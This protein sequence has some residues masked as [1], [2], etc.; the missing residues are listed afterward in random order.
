MK[1]HWGVQ[2]YPQVPGHEIVG[3][4]AAVGKNVTRFKIGDRAGVGC[5]VNSTL[6]DSELMQLENTEQYSPALWFP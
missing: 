5:M 2:K 1:G 4:V 6:P 3:I